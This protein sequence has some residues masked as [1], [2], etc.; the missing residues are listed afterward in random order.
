MVFDIS[1]M[2][3]TDISALKKQLEEKIK[4]DVE[5]LYP[6]V[7]IKHVG[8]DT[9]A[10]IP[11]VDAETLGLVDVGKYP[12]HVVTPEKLGNESV[13]RGLDGYDRP[14]IAIKVNLLD[15]ETKSKVTQVVEVVFRRHDYSSGGVYATALSNKGSDGKSYESGLYMSGGMR[16]YQFK[17]VGLLV[18]GDEIQHEFD[19]R[20]LMQKA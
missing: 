12:T 18:N 9:L 19:K 7:L 16:D 15:S 13:V 10:N 5:K 6:S 20:Y 4:K 2:S 3:M 11:V 8:L 1:K 14:F 17:R